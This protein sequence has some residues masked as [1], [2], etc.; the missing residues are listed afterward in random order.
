MTDERRNLIETAQILIARHFARRFRARSASFHFALTAGEMSTPAGLPR[1]GPRP[2][3]LP[4]R[5]ELFSS[6]IPPLTQL[7][8]SPN[9]SPQRVWHPSRD[10]A[11][12]ASCPSP[13]QRRCAA[14][15][16]G[17]GDPAARPGSGVTQLQNRGADRGP[18]AGS[19]PGVVVATGSFTQLSAFR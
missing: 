17:R 8:E 12:H 11:P 3:A 6:T 9:S 10:P 15:D 16:P 18:Q 1:W 4:A 2:P 5:C 13:P 19:P 7:R 14:G